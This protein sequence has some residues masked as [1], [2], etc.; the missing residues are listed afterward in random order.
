MKTIKKLKKNS[1]KKRN[2]LKV[3][4]IKEELYLRSHLLCPT[5]GNNMTGSASKSKTGH[6]H[7]YYHF[8]HCHKIRFR[9][10]K[11]HEMVL[12]IISEIN[13]SKSANELYNL[14]VKKIFQEKRTQR[15][16]SEESLNTK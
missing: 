3:Q 13:F 5:C 6:K 11:A 9:A 4:T 15:K 8:N 12:S 16:S 7:N 2:M 10:D 14:M 1:G